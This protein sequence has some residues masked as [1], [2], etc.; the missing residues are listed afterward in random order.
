MW[1]SYEYTTA[2][3]DVPQ[4]KQRVKLEAIH[5][6]CHGA[7]PKIAH[8][9]NYIFQQG[10]LAKHLRTKVYWQSICGKKVEEHADLLELLAV[11]EG[12]A[13]DKTLRLVIGMSSIGV[14]VDK[15]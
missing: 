12:V 7:D 5:T 14:S 10:Y 1:F 8:L 6:H 3:G 13:E 15:A 11:G 2:P 9:T 4:V